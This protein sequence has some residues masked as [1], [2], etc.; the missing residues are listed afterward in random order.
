M[1]NSTAPTTVPNTPQREDDFI[2]KTGQ[3]IFGTV[4][5]VYYRY[6]IFSPDAPIV[7]FFTYRSHDHYPSREE[8]ERGEKIHPTYRYFRRRGI[9]IMSFV[10]I[11]RHNWYISPEFREFTKLL[12]KHFAG[13][14]RRIVIG[15]SMG[16]YGAGLHGDNLK[17][18]LAVLFS[19]ISTLD[20]AV[21]PFDLRFYERSYKGWAD[22]AID[23]ANSKCKKLVVY[24][25]TFHIDSLHAKR[26]ANA[27]TL[28]VPGGGHETS[29]MVSK[30]Q[31]LEWL[32]DAV[33][34]ENFTRSEFYY[35]VRRKR[36]L[37][38]FYDRLMSDK[39]TNDHLTEKRGRVIEEYKRMAEALW[40]HKIHG[41]FFDIVNSGPHNI[42]IAIATFNSK[43]LFYSV[44]T[45]QLHVDEMYSSG[46]LTPVL[47]EAK[48][49]KLMAKGIGYLS[50]SRRG[51]AVVKS[52]SA[53]K[54]GKLFGENRH[55]IQ[56]GNRKYYLCVTNKCEVELREGVCLWEKFALFAS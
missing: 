42:K 14:K 16:A 13:F 54:V 20:P 48:T 34:A 33:L 1:L 45:K 28:H 50:F 2:I 31:Q 30:I 3:D 17:A 29:Q 5:N 46:S 35:R 32:Q 4:D 10:C 47:V 53:C 6:H 23:L 25:P 15:S 21:V 7:F 44:E 39:K 56:T 24:D 27:E 19:P 52:R 22:S 38:Q 55:Y 9:N 43:Q 11:E 18:D 26:I 49:G 36:T 37:E 8:A 12:G 41:C 51:C 40:E